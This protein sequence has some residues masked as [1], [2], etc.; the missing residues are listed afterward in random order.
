MLPLLKDFDAKLSEHLLPDVSGYRSRCSRLD[1]RTGR[2]V[3][4]ATTH[5]CRAAFVDTVRKSRTGLEPLRRQ[6]G[7]QELFT[8]LSRL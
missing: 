1:R 4:K 6:T 3:F 8:E 7:V 2:F 5:E